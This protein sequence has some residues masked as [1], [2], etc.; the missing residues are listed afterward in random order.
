V[1]GGPGNDTLIAARAGSALDGG[2]GHD[3]LRGGPGDDVLAGG[4][5]SD[6]VRGGSGRDELHADA[7]AEP[8]GAYDPVAPGSYGSAR[9]RDVLAGGPGVTGCA[10]GP[11][12]TGSRAALGSTSSAIRTAR[13]C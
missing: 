6:D 10:R 2:G 4:A 13:P 8:D 12:A 3:T 7:T 9:D 5:G 11:A 1:A